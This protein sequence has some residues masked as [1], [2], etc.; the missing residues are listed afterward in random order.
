MNVKQIT[1][2]LEDKPGTLHAAL[3]TLAENNIH[4]R[5][6]T[7]VD[8]GGMT[9]LRLIVDNIIYATSLLKNAGYQ[10][11]FTEVFIA[12]VSDPEN[13]LLKVLDL[14]SDAG[15][16]IQHVY[17]ITSKSARW[18]GREIYMVF[19]VNNNARAMEILREEGVTLLTQD[20][21][22]GL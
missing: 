5:A 15:I 21:I 4:I 16:N 19:E 22:A 17:P 2:F 12:E 14:V 1:I 13:G 6:F 18:I 8:M 20:E 11:N 3:K 7:A 9:I 10:A